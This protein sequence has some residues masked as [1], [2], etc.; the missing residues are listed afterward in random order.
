MLVKAEVGV[1][2]RLALVFS[3]KPQMGGD[4]LLIELG[5]CSC[6]CLGLPIY[7]VGRKLFGSKLK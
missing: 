7:S 1:R 6:S 4:I 2:A 5:S 3:G